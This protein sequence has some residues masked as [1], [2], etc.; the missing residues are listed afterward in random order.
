MRNGL[1]IVSL[2]IALWA[3]LATPGRAQQVNPS[4]V[5]GRMIAAFQNCGPPPVY[6]VLTPQLFQIVAQQTGGS[7]CYPVI[8]AAG[9]VVN[10]QVLGQQTFPVGPLYLIRVQHQS[11]VTFDWFMGLNLLINKVQVLMFQPGGGSTMPTIATGPTLGNGSGGGG[12]SGGS[13]P[14]ASQTTPPPANCSL[15]A[16]MC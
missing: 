2:A 7:G 14:P 6:Q 16:G 9:P 11:G 1:W 15:Y 12:T 10:M 3:S 4:L 5:L 13:S 8:Q